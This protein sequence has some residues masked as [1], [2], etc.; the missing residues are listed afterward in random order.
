MNDKRIIGLLIALL[1]CATVEKVR[2]DSPVHMPSVEVKA[3]R[4]FLDSEISFDPATKQ[5]RRVIVSWSR[6][7]LYKHGIQAGD[8]ITLIDERPTG[9]YSFEEA[10]ALLNGE[11]KPGEKRSMWFEGKRGLFRRSSVIFQVTFVGTGKT[12]PN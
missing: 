11:L 3:A 12:E 2:A 1:G 9:K 7:G 6:P 8:V 4:G 10:S 5:V